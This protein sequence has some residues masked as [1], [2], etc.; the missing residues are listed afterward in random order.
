MAPSQVRCLDSERLRAVASGGGMYALYVPKSLVLDDAGQASVWVAEK[1]RAKRV[2]VT[3][4]RRTRDKW[5]EVADGLKDG[6][7]LIAGDLK[8]LRDGDKITVIGESKDYN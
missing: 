3:L 6:D 4:G 7:R 8:D 5:V 1:G 2:T